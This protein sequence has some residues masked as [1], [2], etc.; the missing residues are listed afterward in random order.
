VP[1]PA[2]VTQ[3]IR[4]A[5]RLL[6]ILSTAAMLDYAALV[7]QQWF[8]G[9]AARVAVRRGRAWDRLDFTEP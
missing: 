1:H 8:S 4:V 6:V 3:R 7:P 2:D 5:A 9:R